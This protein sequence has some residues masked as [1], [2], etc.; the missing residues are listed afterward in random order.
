MQQACKM[1]N[2]AAKVASGGWSAAEV[3][4]SLAR[5]DLEFLEAEILFRLLFDV[6]QQWRGRVCSEAR[7]RGWHQIINEAPAGEGAERA[8]WSMII[9]LGDLASLCLHGVA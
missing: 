6:W 4:A 7:L 2:D 8:T 5:L 9:A 3:L 1:I